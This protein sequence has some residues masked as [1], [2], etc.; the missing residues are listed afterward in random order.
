MS[1]TNEDTARSAGRRFGLW[2]VLFILLGASVLVSLGIGR[3]AVPIS[4]VAGILISNVLPIE[5]A[6]PV[7]EERVVELIRMPRILMAGLAGAGLAVAGAALQG[8]F[9]NPLVG[10]QIIGVSS[11]A[12]FGGA[13]AILV[14][15]SQVLLI[16][17]AFGFGLLAMV[18][19]YTISRQQGRA[20]ILML[21]LSGI[22]TSAFF[23]A[24]VSITKF[25]ADPDDKLPAI[26]FW[27]M[28]SFAS[29]SYDKVLLIAIPVVA[30]TLVVYLMR[31][32]INVLSLGDE[33]A[34][35]LGLKV[36]RT[37][38]IVLVAVALISAAVVAAAGIVGWV[39]LV[40][41]HFARM[42]TGPDHK[43]LIPASA[44][45]GA[46][47]LIHVDNVARASIPAEI[48]VGIITA[49]LGAPVFAYLLRRAANKGWSSE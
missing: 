28:G 19:V 32:Q 31:F 30:G 35:T 33:E 34:Q 40:I 23:S 26:V 9:R 1:I 3:F 44:L 15:E 45:I 2:G 24:L 48:P 29:A 21:V 20:S 25:V 38:W 4:H 41:P 22:V 14:S 10:P 17:G 27:L 12:A 11:G 46:I 42:L 49:L 36:E 16:G 47:Y 37:R 8:V 43:L 39:G 7:V 6:W 18:V 5:Q 13:F